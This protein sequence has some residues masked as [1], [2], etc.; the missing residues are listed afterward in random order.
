[1]YITGGIG[2]T[3][4]GEA[5]SYN[6]DLPNDLAYS[7]TCA[8]I[9][10]IFFAK[11][12]LEINPCS[13]YANVMER[14][15]YN[16]VLHAMSEDGKS[17]FYTN[18]LEV[19]PKASRLDSR[20]RHIKPTRQKWFG[21]ACCPPNLA[22]LISSLNDYCISS[23]DNNIFVHMYIGGNFSNDEAKISINSNYLT[24]GEVEFDITVYK[25]F[26]LALRIPDWCNEFE[27]N[28]EYKAI[29]GYAYVDIKDSTSI[30]IKFNIEPK[31][32]KCS[33]LVRAN[34]GK[35]AVMRGPIVYCAEEIDNCE[36]LQLLLIDKKSK[37]SV[38][39]DLSITVNGF[40]EKANSTLYYDYNE[41]ELENYKITLIPYYKSCNRGENEM[42]V[43]LRI[44]E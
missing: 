43:Y 26:K 28:K 32:V 5:F 35:V 29:N 44:K 1:M 41:S 40:K 3:V 38:N 7:E 36:N 24:H 2:S 20:K 14:A 12:M 19:L 6:Y 15:F 30:S 33:N 16:T 8:S 39:D 31:L 34:I 25:P 13:K 9:G 42:S 18:A 21:C 10:L 11:R 17:F 37:F 4:D 23:N 27:I 22:R